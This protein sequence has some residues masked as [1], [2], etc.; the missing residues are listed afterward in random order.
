MLT[1]EVFKIKIK[2]LVLAETVTHLL[3][4]PVVEVGRDALVV[5]HALEALEEAIPFVLEAEVIQVGEED[6]AL[7]WFCYQRALL[8]A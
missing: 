7:L 4:L 1:H 2:R 8:L 3:D 5:H 6:G